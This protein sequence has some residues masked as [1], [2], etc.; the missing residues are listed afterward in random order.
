MREKLRIFERLLSEYLKYLVSLLLLLCS[1]KNQAGLE[2]TSG[3]PL[4]LGLF[5][6]IL[7]QEQIHL[8]KEV[9]RAKNPKY[10]QCPCL[11]LTA[12]VSH[13]SIV[14]LSNMNNNLLRLMCCCHQFDFVPVWQTDLEIEEVV[15]SRS[16]NNNRNNNNVNSDGRFHIKW[17]LDHICRVECHVSYTT[18]LELLVFS[19]YGFWGEL[20]LWKL[21]YHRPHLYHH[22]FLTP[23]DW[24]L[25]LKINDRHRLQSF[26]KSVSPLSVIIQ[27]TMQHP[28]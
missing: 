6:S 3:F 25:W 8:G 22:Q 28:H 15:W 17:I 11:R 13:F 27:V 1:G 23:D 9:E 19:E 24:R 10:T 7:S 5:L 12:I 21:G 2:L 16:C 4:I 14:Y 26:V 18:N 20:P